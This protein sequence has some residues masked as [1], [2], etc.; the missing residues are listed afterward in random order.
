MIIDNVSD[1]VRGA[2]QLE[3]DHALIHWAKSRTLPVTVVES[4]ALKR[5]GILC[6]FQSQFEL[7]LDYLNSSETLKNL[8]RSDIKVG[9]PKK[10]AGESRQTRSVV[11]KGF[12]V[13]KTDEKDKDL[14]EKLVHW[15]Q[16]ECQDHQGCEYDKM[17]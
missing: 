15:F 13:C 11:I 2:S 9:H 3:I 10:A 8:F 5:G 4:R 6:K 7:S 14:M 12:K 1:Q 17:G 16:I